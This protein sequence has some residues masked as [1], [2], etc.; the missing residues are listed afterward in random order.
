MTLSIQGYTDAFAI[1][2]PMCSAPLK[3]R[4]SFGVPC[5]NSIIESSM[6]IRPSRVPFAC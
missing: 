6:G 5:S 3:N 4:A 1:G 2:Y